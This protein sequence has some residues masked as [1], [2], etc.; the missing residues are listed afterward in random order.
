VNESG[1]VLW[2]QDGEVVSFTIGSQLDPRI[3]SDG[4]KGAII[5]FPDTRGTSWDIYAQR[6]EQNGFWGYPAPDITGVR[7]VPGDQGGYINLSWDASRLDIDPEDRIEHY[8]IWRAIEETTAMAMIESGARLITSVPCLI[9][10]GSEG[11]TIHDPTQS[12]PI[13]KQPVIRREMFG[14]DIYYWAL[15]DTVESSHYVDTYSMTVPTLF[16]STGA[17]FEYHYFQ[18]IAHES[19]PYGWWVSDVDSGYS[20]DN[21]APYAP[22]CLAG[23]QSFAPVGLKITWA[24]NEEPD[25]DQYVIYRG[26]SDDFIPGPGNLIVSLDETQYFDSDWR[27]DAGYWY[28]VTAIDINGNESCYALLGSDTITG[29]TVPLIPLATCLKQNYPNP[30]NP[31]TV[32]KFDLAQAVYVKLS[33]YDVK[34]ELVSTLVNQNMTE[35]RKDIIWSATDNRGRAVSSGIY[36]YRLDAGS[37]TETK[38]MVLMR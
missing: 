10:K 37:F 27:W 8:S 22:Q 4:A 11:P 33:I 26:A 15:V 20:I 17:S 2:A 1:A 13:E 28:K 30:F 25:F 24:S 14:N 29:D 32:I 5:A 31:T 23:E 38:K 36:F 19:D 9:E 34:G 3:V 18:V 35:G 16:D 21:L 7:D 6:I 12:V